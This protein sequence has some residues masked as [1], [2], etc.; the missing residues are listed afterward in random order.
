[1]YIDDSLFI[2]SEKEMEEIEMDLF[3]NFSAEEIEEY[4]LDLEI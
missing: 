1:M 3:P 2:F 4:Y